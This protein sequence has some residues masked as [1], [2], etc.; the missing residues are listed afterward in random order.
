[1]GNILGIDL[2]TTNI[3]ASLVQADGKVIQLQLGTPPR[4][5]TMRSAVLFQ[6]GGKLVA[7]N[8]AP[9][10]YQRW[11]DEHHHAPDRGADGP[12]LLEAFK[13]LLAERAR[14][15]TVWVKQI[16]PGKLADHPSDEG[17]TKVGREERYVLQTEALR[18]NCPP[19]FNLNDVYKATVAL[20]QAVKETLAKD[21]G[22]V[23]L[24]RVVVGVPVGFSDI[25]REKII[26]AV[27]EAGLVSARSV[28]LVHEPLSVA[29]TYGAQT[30]APRRVLVFDNGGGTVDMTVLDIYVQG[31]RDLSYRVV[32]QASHERAGRHYD[33]L[34]FRR[35]VEDAGAEKDYILS[36]LGIQDP[37]EVQH[38]LVLDA[39]E[40]VKERL[41]S[42]HP[43]G[44]I[45]GRRP[46]ASAPG[47]GSEGYPF[48]YPFGKL[49][50]RR[51]VRPENFSQAVCK[52]LA[53]LRQRLQDLLTDASERTHSGL[54]GVN[55]AGIEEV[56]M[57]GGSSLLPCMQDLIR[58]V[59][60][61]V[62]INTVYAG[63][64]T[65]TAGL[66]H[67]ARY[68]H[69]IEELTDCRYGLLDPNTGSVEPIV[70][71]SIPIS[72]TRFETTIGRRD[73]FYIKPQDRDVTL[74]LFASRR[75]RWN[76]HLS[77]RVRAPKED[78]TLQVVVEIDRD[79]GRPVPRAHSCSTGDE[80]QPEVDTELRDLAVLESGQIIRF[81]DNQLQA[82]QRKG[83]GCI[84]NIEYIPSGKRSDYAVGDIRSYRLLL[85][86]PE[87]AT[88]K[89]V[90]GNSSIEFVDV[91][92]PDPGTSIELS[93]IDPKMLRP[94]PAASPVGAFTRIPRPALVVLPSVT[95]ATTGP[96][97]EIVTALREQAAGEASRE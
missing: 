64:R 85:H 25:G 77:I 44:G 8:R 30:R 80:L 22:T 73:G 94:L 95:R 68:R 59:L 27:E 84:E 32:A 78:C 92:T 53:V 66:A 16:A 29:L 42:S 17:T 12:R 5:E 63:S 56:L 20:L 88:V 52:E 97:H 50:F 10:E 86:T 2:G 14:G 26:E 31:G 62:P 91:E 41:F 45:Y 48:T 75:E 58:D 61:G 23:A 65:T 60:P 93:R 82:Y 19:G 43:E 87:N 69:L 36:H 49:S 81:S 57:A 34:L 38:P 67:A 83:V 89:V 40:R 15:R 72:D 76:P 6:P 18:Q 39:V 54:S 47:P 1:M 90:A 3:S 70:S 33:R 11:L 74:V 71:P 55:A 37:M 4:L 46:K 51:V 13:P 9:H 35:I 28:S 96:A 7:G 24:E 21:L 79:T